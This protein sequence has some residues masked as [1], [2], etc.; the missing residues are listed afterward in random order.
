MTL[1]YVMMFYFYFL[2]A[3]LSVQ[4]LLVNEAQLKAIETLKAGRA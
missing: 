4:L 2:L 1:L 3:C